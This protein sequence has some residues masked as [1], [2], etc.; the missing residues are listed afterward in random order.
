MLEG[1]LFYPE[2]ESTLKALSYFCDYQ[3]E[4]PNWQMLFLALFLPLIL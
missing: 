2:K 3:D 4:A 1:R